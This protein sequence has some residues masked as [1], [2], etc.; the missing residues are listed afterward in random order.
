MG[1]QLAEGGGPGKGGM[2]AERAIRAAAAT[3][4]FRGVDEGFLSMKSSYP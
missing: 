2:R 1:K 3:M 4:S